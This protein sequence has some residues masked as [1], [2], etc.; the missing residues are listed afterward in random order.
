MFLVPL[1]LTC[2]FRLWWTAMEKVHSQSLFCFLAVLRLVAQGKATQSGFQS[3]F[4]ELSVKLNGIRTVLHRMK[5][6]CC[7]LKIYN[8]FNLTQMKVLW[9]KLFCRHLFWMVIWFLAL[10]MEDLSWGLAAVFM[11]PHVFWGLVFQSRSPQLLQVQFFVLATNFAFKVAFGAGKAALT[12]VCRTARCGGQPELWGEFETV[13]QFCLQG[14][15]GSDQ[16]C[17]LGEGFSIRRC[18]YFSCCILC[19]DTGLPCEM[20]VCPC[21]ARGR[22]CARLPWYH[23]V[24]WAR[25][26]VSAELFF[27]V[28]AENELLLGPPSVPLRELAEMT[29]RKRIW[30]LLGA[31]DVKKRPLCPW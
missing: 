5:L 7:V 12:S 14:W 31:D 19:A 22:W 8:Y 11:C 17:S 3:I 16:L 28:H 26:A 23:K 4:V 15:G 24:L 2:L 18:G 27:T 9:A 13:L 21:S 6:S 1:L 29:S 20:R 10:H 30:R 25:K